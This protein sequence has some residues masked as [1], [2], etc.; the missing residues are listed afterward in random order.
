MAE[1]S[2][3]R[4]PY[5][6]VPFSNKVLEYP[7]EIPG[8]DSTDPE[9]KTGEIHVTLKAATPV[10]VWDGKDGKDKE[11]HFIKGPN[12]KYMVPG[13]TIRGLVRQNMQILGFGLVRP[14]KDLENKRLFYRRLADGTNTVY[15]ALKKHYHSVLNVTPHKTPD[16]EKTYFVPE[17]V[18]AG[19]LRRKKDGSGYQIQPVKGTFLRVSRKHPDVIA[20]G[21]EPSRALAVSYVAVGERVEK[22]CLGEVPGM[23]HGRLLYTGKPVSRIPN[24]LY[25]FPSPDNEA[26]PVELEED[27]LLNATDQ[28]LRANFLRGGGNDPEFWSLPKGEEEKPVFY[29]RYQGH[30]YFGMNLYLRLRYLNSIADGLPDK[31]KKLLSQ[32]PEFMDYPQA[33][34]GYAGEKESRRSRVSFGDFQVC[35]NPNELEPIT[36]ILGEPKTSYFPSYIVEGKHYDEDDFQLRGYKYYWLKETKAALPTSEKTKSVLCPLPAGT[37]FSGVIR[38]K[39]LKPDELGLLLWSLHLKE[40]YWQSIGMGKPYGFGRIELSLDEVR[41]FN[42]DTLYT[43]DGLCSRGTVLTETEIEICINRYRHSPETAKALYIKKKK[44]SVDSLSEIKDFFYLTSTIRK[45]D[46]VSYMS[47]S[48][49]SKMLC[50]LPTVRDIRSSES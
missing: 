25:L 18:K 6:F 17:N 47:V 3:V 12:G 28:E 16:G 2:I 15:G 7:G 46:E 44:P 43:P 19:Y 22:L 48:E 41:E 34:L 13:S 40:T 42:L 49:H 20:F 37:M 38:Y 10:L 35:G 8:H 21:D 39:N 31:Q 23:A 5:N 33:I 45:P 29:V 36:T 26:D 4:A 27:A 32:Q 24:H 9:L 30:T 14:G 11:K 50:P 1:N